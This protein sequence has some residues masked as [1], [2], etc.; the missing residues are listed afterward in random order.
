MG[1]Q[2]YWWCGKKMLVWKKEKKKEPKDPIQFALEWISHLAEQE[3]PTPEAAPALL[4]FHLSSPHSQVCDIVDTHGASW[5]LMVAHGEVGKGL[6]CTPPT[7]VCVSPGMWSMGRG[8]T[9]RLS[10]EAPQ[11]DLM[12]RIHLPCWSETALVCQPPGRVA[13]HICFPKLRKT[14][15]TLA[16]D[17][18]EWKFLFICWV[19]IYVNDW[20]KEG[21]GLESRL[22]VGLGNLSRQHSA[23]MT[24]ECTFPENK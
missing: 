11:Q 12:L 4:L 23:L 10:V 8:S 2:N 5:Q 3:L 15:R 22:S 20:A 7:C 19:M 9:T 1:S 17:H 18:K 21:G 14:G 16:R 13:K 6:P 24:R